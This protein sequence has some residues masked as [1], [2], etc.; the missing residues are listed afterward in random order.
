MAQQKTEPLAFLA[1]PWPAI[2]LIVLAGLLAF[3]NNYHGE[4]IYDDIDTVVNNQTI[5][6]FSPIWRPLWVTHLT[7]ITGRPT[8]ALTFALNYAVGGLN[9]VGYHLVNNI[10]HLLVGLTLFGIIRATLLLP[11]FAPK[12]ASRANAFG[13]AVTL[14]WLIHPLQ[15]E[16]VNY[17]T[18]RTETLTALLYLLTILCAIKSFTLESPRRW[19]A[20]AVIAC[21]LGMGGKE[22]MVSAPLM[23][24]FYDRLFVA[25]SFQQALHR[26]KRLYGWL[27]ATWIILA[28][29]QMGAPHG[30]AVR[31]DGFG[32]LNVT[33]FDYFRTQFGVVL[34]Y[35][36]LSFWPH[37]LALSY[38][39]VPFIREFTPRLIL[40]MAFFS[41]TAVLSF[42]GLA[43]GRWWSILGLWFFAIISPSS[44][45]IPMPLEIATERRMYLPLAALIVL[46]VFIVDHHW[47]RFCARL[48]PGHRPLRHAAAAL[49]VIIVPLMGYATWQRN[50]DY[51]T[52]VG[53]WQDTVDTRPGNAHALENLGKAL[54]DEGRVAEAIAPFQEALALQPDNAETLSNLGSA[55]GKVGRFSEAVSMHQKA[56]E[57]EPDNAMHHYHLGN[58]FLRANDLDNAARSFRQT[59]RLDPEAYSAHGNLGIL[60]MQQGDLNGAEGHLTKLLDLMPDSVIGYRL[61]AD[62][63]I[64]QN[65]GEEAARLYRA[66]LTLAPGDPDLTAR[67][68][69]LTSAP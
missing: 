39:D 49:L 36:R 26:R 13:L 64:A 32:K 4:F 17:I 63:R 43:R 47:S 30:S 57:L 16:A 7:P 23:V 11:R 28:L 41:A 24:L 52:A 18:Q 1:S 56:V 10:I 3:S 50:N 5:K 21:A 33:P 8:I 48:P 60:L 44:S 42:W 61:L 67:L 9:V 58:T 51:R 29:L 54:V 2:A 62:L 31:F 15:T 55:L 53:I 14:P 35:L 6:S 25:G 27:A 12:F 37:P 46:M 20:A 19:Q 69:A 66:A 59:V 68:N 22:I 34:H 45:I 40:P 65:R 38:Q